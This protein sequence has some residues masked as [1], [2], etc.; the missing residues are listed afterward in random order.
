MKK[1]IIF[2]LAL[3]VLFSSR[4]SFATKPSDYG[5]K[6]GDLI[7]AIFSDDPDVYIINE[8]GYKRLFLNPEIFKFYAHLGGFANIKLITPEIRDSFPTSGFFRNCEDNDQKVFGTSVE[9]EDTG[10]LHWINKSGDQAVQEDP[11]FFKKVFCINRKEFNWYPRGNEFKALEE[12][13]QYSRKLEIENIVI[14][15][16]PTDDPRTFQTIRVAPESLNAHFQHGDT[17]GACPAYPLPEPTPTPVPTPTPIP[18]PTPTPTLTPTPT[19]TPIPTPTPTPTPTP[20]PTSIPQATPTPTPTPTPVATSPVTLIS[21][22][23]GECMAG[24]FPITWTSSLGSEVSNWR[25]MYSLDNGSTWWYV[26]YL[27]NS[28]AR[29]Y[30]Y[31]ASGDVVTRSDMDSNQVLMRVQ[32]YSPTFPGG[33]LLGS[34]ISD[35]VFSVH[36]T[37]PGG[38]IPAA[39]SNLT[40]TPKTYST[41]TQSI[42][43][44]WTDNSN[45][46]LGFAAYKRVLGDSR[47]DNPVY[48]SGTAIEYQGLQAG[49]T[50]EFKVRAGNQYG[51]SSAATITATAGT[52]VSTPTPTPTLSPSPTPTPVPSP[53]PTPTP[54]PT[55]TPIPTSVIAPTSVA[56]GYYKGFS[57][58]PPTG[59]YQLATSL[60]Y[61]GNLSDVQSFRLY[62]KK[63][64]ESLFSAVATFLSPSSIGPVSSGCGNQ[65][66]FGEWSMRS[67]AASSWQIFGPSGPSSS[68]PVGEYSAYVVA[69]NNSGIEGAGSS[70]AISIL[71]KTTVLSPVGT[72]NSL[73]PQFRWP[74]PSNW[75]TGFWW[76]QIYDG[77]NFSWSKS[78][79]SLV[80]ATEGSTIYDGPALSPSK[81]YYVNIWAEGWMAGNY[82]DGFRYFSMGESNPSFTVTASS[83]AQVNFKTNSFAAFHRNLTVGSTGDDV[84]Q[85]QALLVNEVGYSADLLTG[86]FGRITRDAVKR[87]QEKYGVRPA[88]GYFGAIT[89]KA[90]NAL[91]SSQ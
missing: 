22:N 78:V 26:I 16:H 74:I 82:S 13:P 8:H 36:P 31:W 38:T 14:C 25:L 83:T 73:I 59:R 10:R 63:P 33:T 6:E 68:H 42:V 18:T 48:V 24:I 3:V 45:N 52:S 84:K 67:C 80:G 19:F 58:Q 90:L 79:S 85:L 29:S 51:Y 75:S 37:C 53:S 23:G 55:P 81:T 7:S 1:Y 2:I 30:N 41:G 89:R 60:T 5:L 77:A 76:P 35:R 44:N 39:P 70:I 47:W 12:V 49:T 62:L 69:I 56:I 91:I 46:E 32:A 28:G 57:G 9:G 50:Y 88:S 65:I 64:G 61:S 34:D 15:H 40:A 66:Y 27:H 11:D 21:P 43:L 87:L 17:Y 86:Y 54:T 20:V 72:Q 71:S 4:F